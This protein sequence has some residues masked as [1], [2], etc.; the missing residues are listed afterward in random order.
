MKMH[1]KIP[2]FYTTSVAL[3]KATGLAII[4]LVG[5]CFFL[6]IRKVD[7]EPN[8]SNAERKSPLEIMK[9]AI[10]VRGHLKSENE[11]TLGLYL[12]LQ[13]FSYLTCKSGLPSTVLSKFW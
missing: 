13:I 6:L 4:S 10:S 1:L 12:R 11:I 9:S 3:Q 7:D 8:E 5:T 2:E